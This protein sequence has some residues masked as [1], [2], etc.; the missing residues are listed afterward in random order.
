[1]RSTLH[2]GT[3]GTGF[4]PK[5]YATVLQILAH[6]DPCLEVE[7]GKDQLFNQRQAARWFNQMVLVA[8]E[9]LQ[10]ILKTLF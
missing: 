4:I 9:W 7:V 2:N 5:S 1:M 3:E 8:K 10:E 6:I